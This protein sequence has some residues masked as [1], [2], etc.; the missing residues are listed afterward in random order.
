MITSDGLVAV[1][2]IGGEVAT[3]TVG[4]GRTQDLVSAARPLGTSLPY[5]LSDLPWGGPRVAAPQGETTANFTF[6]IFATGLSTRHSEDPKTPNTSPS[7]TNSVFMLKMV[8]LAYGFD[9]GYDVYS[10]FGRLGPFC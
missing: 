4:L 1:Q 10:M 7:S 5:A 2:L 6:W 3:R 9:V 8:A